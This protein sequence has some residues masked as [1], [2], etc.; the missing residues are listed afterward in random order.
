MRSQDLSSD[1]VLINGDIRT[2]DDGLGQVQAVAVKDG[3][4]VALG[5]TEE[6]K[7]LSGPQTKTIDLAGRTV[8]PGIFDAHV[9]V[10]E[11]G[12]KL[13][14]IA[15]D[16]C[17]SI[18]EMVE[19]VRERAEATPRGEW[20]IGHGW[21]EN[22]FA[23][24][25]LPTRHD[26]DE[27]TTD[28]PVVLMRVFN[29]YVVNTAALQAAGI[30]KHTP[31][32]SGGEIIHDADGSPNGLL[33]A[34][35]KNL[36]MP[37]LPQPSEE[38]MKR[39]VKI[40]TDRLHSFGI[41]SFLEPGL[42]PWEIGAYQTMLEEGSLTARVNV[43]VSWYGYWCA[44]ES[45]EQLAY[46]AQEMGLRSGF[47]DEWLRLGGLKMALDGGI[48]PHTAFM[49][50]PFEGEEKPVDYNR[51]DVD[52]LPA[53][54]ETAQELGWDVGI[55][56]M[57]DRAQDVAVDGLAG[58]IQA[59]PRPNARHNVIHGTFPT[60]Q[61]MERMAE[62]DIAVVIQPSAL[63][64]DS[65]SYFAHVG[66]E[67]MA[68]YKPARSYIDHGVRVVS[69]SDMIYTKSANPFVGLYAL[70]TRKNARSQVVG[71]EEGLTREEALRSYTAGG[72]W[73][74]R[75]ERFKGTLALGKL[76]D[77]AVLDRDYFSVPE[78]EIKEIE[79]EMTIVG[80]EVV[81]RRAGS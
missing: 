68:R 7:T 26:I 28:H 51:L 81:Y 75:E 56:C 52:K 60:R 23:E 4:I 13:D 40:G 31:D 36:V 16:D 63:Y 5:E 44:Y 69:S 11:M 72:A 55:H 1:V 43:M 53:Y 47:G 66:P 41:T 35:A 67:R 34:N 48:A 10:M 78:E 21:N 15:L 38:A 27:A 54:F 29:K 76:A 74:T 70:V 9:H 37:F 73:L 17:E 64:Y 42:R 19:R 22:D 18:E 59:I 46:R 61:A 12:I 79:V 57:G 25:R 33:F 45:D 49:Y 24:D 2:M 32:P 14:W 58:V 3:R 50:E 77:M 8:I 62:H 6:V 80:G 30:D 71:A 20:I 39:A 65:G